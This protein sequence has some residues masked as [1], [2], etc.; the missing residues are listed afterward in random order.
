MPPAPFRAIFLDF[1]DTLYPFRVSE[2]NQFLR[3]LHDFLQ[4]RLAQPL[5]Y[6]LFIVLYDEVRTRQFTD[7]RATLREHD[8]TARICEVV[9]FCRSGLTEEKP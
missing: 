6:N 1:A 7:H 3:S 8:F 4:R 2:T 5:N 9:E